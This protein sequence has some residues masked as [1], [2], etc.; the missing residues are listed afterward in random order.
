MYP[1]NSLVLSNIHNLVDDA[2]EDLKSCLTNGECTTEWDVYDLI[3]EIADRHVPVYN[4]DLLEVAMSNLRLAT[5]EPELWPA[6]WQNTPVYL[7]MT[8]VYEYLSNELA[9]WYN[10]N[11]T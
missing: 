10:E 7:I 4:S 2:I 9:E 8:N 6:F 5:T 3:H 11:E 1:T